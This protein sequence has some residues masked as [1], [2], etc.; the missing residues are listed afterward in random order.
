MHRVGYLTIRTFSTRVEAEIA[1]QTLLANG[2]HAIISIDDAGGAYPFPLV[3]GARLMVEK[4]YKNK[5]EDLLH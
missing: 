1:K 4:K 2:I 5:A 3:P